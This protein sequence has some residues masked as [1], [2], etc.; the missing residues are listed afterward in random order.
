MKKKNLLTL[1]AAFATVIATSMATSA[2][3]FYFYQP[4]EPESLR[5]K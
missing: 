4:E 1:V 2:C 3:I 5:D